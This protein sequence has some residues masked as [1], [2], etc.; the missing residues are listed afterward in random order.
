MTEKTTKN[1]KKI[2]N[3]SGEHTLNVL[4]VDAPL[5]PQSGVESKQQLTSFMDAKAPPVV[6]IPSSTD[7]LRSRIQVND[8]SL[9]NFM[10][11]PIKIKSYEWTPLSN[12]FTVSFDPW[13]DF[14]LNPRISNRISN[15]KLGRWK[16][17][18]KFVINGN[19][20]YSGR[21]MAWYQP[22]I[23]FDDMT[24]IT[25]T[26]T[27]LVGHS[28]FP[29]LFLDPATSMG[30]EMV[31]PFFYPQDYMD[32]TSFAIS[33]LGS[34]HIQTL[35]DLKH[36]QGVAAATECVSISVF[37]WATEV[38]LQAPTHTNLLG[39]IP[40]SGKDEYEGSKGPISKSA[41][42]I[43]AAATALSIIP[44]ISPFATATASAF[45][46]VASVAGA[47]GYS[48]PCL[49]EEPQFVQPRS[50][51]NL[52]VTNTPDASAKLTV[53]VKQ[54]VTLDPRTLGLGSE[55]E[56]SIAYMAGR[57]SYIFSF[58]WAKGT[59]PETLLSNVVV[60]PCFHRRDVG[61]SR[62][63]M[64]ACCGVALPFDY[65]T[66]S[67]VFTLQIVA[68]AFH[69]GRLA[70]VYDPDETPATREG[71]LAYTEIIDIATC[72]D[73]T[74]KISNHQDTT[75]LPHTPVDTLVTIS[76]MF[77][78]T[79]ITNPIGNGTLSFWVINELTSSNV[80]P[81]VND[82]IEINVFMHAAE[83]FEVFVPNEEIHRFVIKPQSGADPVDPM[84][85]DNAP[86]PTVDTSIGTPAPL[87]SNR[88][89]LYSGEKIASY[90]QM[91]KRYYH[92]SAFGFN[93]VS[94]TDDRMALT[95]KFFPYYRGNVD[96]AIH[97]R[98]SST[99]SN[100][101]TFA[102]ITMLNWL[103][104]AFQALRGS[105]RYKIVPKNNV[106]GSFSGDDTYYVSRAV[107]QAYSFST[108]L[109]NNV[110]L[111]TISRDA[112]FSMGAQRTTQGATAFN[113]RVNPVVEFEVPYYS[114]FRFSPGKRE[115]WTTGT[116]PY[117]AEAFR[118]QAE[119]END[120]S[121]YFDTWVAAGE[122]FSLYF[123]TGWP[124]LYYE[125]IV[126]LT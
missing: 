63:H 89:L 87:Q 41:T 57:D 50:N 58:P 78:P 26:E 74:I 34:M 114:R 62:V 115:N 18:V 84:D 44:Q 83:D 77:G 125:A 10:S 123:F 73:Y 88:N 110:T 105:V 38:D 119:P 3:C 12:N 4:G 86:Q 24:D 22:L 71:N 39:L 101:Y 32:L 94:G 124:P 103:T 48:A 106:A 36:V 42:A 54:E 122:D 35:T 116:T 98:N 16:M 75:L 31:L 80:D 113:S 99:T 13:T 70:V 69:R 14:Y 68:S 7:E 79:R 49:V 121:K 37:A 30:G 64:P 21:L 52:A 76:T 20:F 91:L 92:H 120:G 59:A 28:Q 107:G 11:R 25:A 47:L 108:D 97:V 126:P 6:E 33:E 1:T 82:D 8:N 56:L 43:A 27:N 67:L 23:A 17:H 118:F 112:L 95:M 96:G 65:W 2:L 93:A 9:A 19:S 104:P 85:D 29:R 55:D 66:G 51:G 81:A 53:D 90:R 109:M 102:G 40:Q 60:D 100:P 5:Y 46:T 111:S 15:Y 72:R 45:S 61:F 117:C